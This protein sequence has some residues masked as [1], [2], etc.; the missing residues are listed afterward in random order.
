MLNLN[1]LFARLDTPNVAY[2]NRGDLTFEDVSSTWG[3]DKRGVS[4]GMCV[5]DLDNDGDMDVVMNNLNEEAGC[6]AM[7]G[8]G[9]GWRC[10]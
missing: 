6:I 3:F 7:R 4:H 9:R 1:N 8:A 5:A 2:R 10:A